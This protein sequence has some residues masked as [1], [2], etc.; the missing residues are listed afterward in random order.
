M[1]GK[2]F[3]LNDET[4]SVIE[5]IGRHMPGG[6]FIYEASGDGNLLYVNRAAMDIYGCADLDEFMELTGY[7]FRGMVYPEDYD[8]SII[9]DSVENRKKRHDMERK[10]TDEVIVTHPGWSNGDGGCG[11]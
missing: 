2:R 5:E 7:T 8:F 6:F 4:L 3:L 10:Y 1:F 11:P 9:F